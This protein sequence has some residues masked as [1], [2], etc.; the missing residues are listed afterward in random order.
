MFASWPVLR[1]IV[2]H[3]EG[4]LTV[5]AGAEKFDSPDPG[6]RRDSELQFAT[7]TPMGRHPL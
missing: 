3:Q 7:P 1:V 6:V 5:N 2:E 4:A